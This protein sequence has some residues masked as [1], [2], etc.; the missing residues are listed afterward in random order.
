MEEEL[1]QICSELRNLL[2][3]AVKEDLAEGILLSGGLDTSILAF[4]AA[5]QV[6]GLKAFTV[7]LEGFDKDLSYAR[8]IA[9]FLG[10]EHRLCFFTQREF[11]EVFPEAAGIVGNQG[12]YLGEPISPSVFVPNYIAL[13]FAKGLVN[14]VYTGDGGD[15]LFF[16]YSS[17][18][19]LGLVIAEDE[20][21]TP[22]IKKELEGCFLSLLEIYNVRFPRDLGKALGMEVKSPYLNQRLVEY[23]SGI[24]FEY[25]V[26]KEKGKAWGKWI[27]RKA[28]ED[29]LPKEIIWREKVPI[30]SG[31]GSIKLLGLLEG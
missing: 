26:R 30:D 24:P 11:L 25:K 31:T 4:L 29:Y 10:L 9:N 13:R 8:K 22:E 18:V 23:A 6:K 12:G 15:E 16:G 20:F 2:E 21:Y 1:S 19:N 28:F 17:M 3:E 14:S 5:K 27:L 7:S